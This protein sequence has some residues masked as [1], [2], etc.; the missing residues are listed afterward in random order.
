MRSPFKRDVEPSNF[1]EGSYSPFCALT[2]IEPLAGV[3]IKVAD[4]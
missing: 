1:A 3:R 2:V 4:P